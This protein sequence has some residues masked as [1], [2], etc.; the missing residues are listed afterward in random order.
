[1]KK[2]LIFGGN[3]FVGKQLSEVLVD[4]YQVDV[5]NR[6]GTSSDKR[7]SVIKG[8][9]NDKEDLNRVD[10][11]Q[12]H[13][14][15][16]MCL[17]LPS[18]FDLIKG[19]ISSET[20]YIF[21]SSGAADHRYVDSFGDYGRD[22]LK[23]EKMLK[24]TDIN[25]DIIRPSYIVGINN[26]RPRLGYFVEKLN[27]DKVI[28]VAGDG[29]NL[30]NIVFVED[31]VK[32]LQKLVLR[33]TPEMKTYNVSGDDSFMV[34]ELIDIVKKKMILR[35][36]QKIKVSYNNSE[37][38]FYDFDFQLDNTKIC[39]DLGINFTKIDDGLGKYLRWYFE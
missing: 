37:S 27:N 29:K 21:V 18:Q 14:I 19:L 34:V 6:S 33:D 25:F 30:I 16:D 32:V 26:H 28:K 20:N 3:R 4:N 10:F 2:V 22:K 9:R 13:T 31:V 5:F 11:N 38:P 15:V 24:S 7:I 35:S 12:Y 36:Q 39:N 1:M 23:I 17:Y 8:D